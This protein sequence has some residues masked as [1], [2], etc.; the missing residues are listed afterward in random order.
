MCVDI[1]WQ[2]TGKISGKY[3]Y[4]MCKCCKKFYGATFL[5][6]T[7]VQARHARPW[8]VVVLRACQ[9]CLT[10][11]SYSSIKTTHKLENL[12]LKTV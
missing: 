9:T 11:L 2:Q 3:T 8:E 10:S 7:V 12:S 6:H 5:T 4:P 1:N